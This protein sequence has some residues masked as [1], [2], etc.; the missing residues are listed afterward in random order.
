MSKEGPPIRDFD[1][2]IWPY[3]R[4]NQPHADISVFGKTVQIDPVKSV[5]F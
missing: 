2:R 3:L 1:R 4:Q 5:A